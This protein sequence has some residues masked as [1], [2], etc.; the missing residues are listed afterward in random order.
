VTTDFR[1][2]TAA[3]LGATNV[4]KST[5]VNRLLDFKVAITSRKPQT[6]RHRIRGVLTT[7]AAQTILI[8]TPG[9]HQPQG[10]L[11]KK[12][13]QT[14]VAALDG[15]DLVALVAD[16]TDRTREDTRRAVAILQQTSGP[17]I[18]VINK[19]DL[20]TKLSLLPIMAEVASWDAFE[21]V[22][23]VSA[24][25]GDGIEV[26]RAE[27]ESRL[28]MGEPIFP[29]EVPTDRTERFLIGELIREQ[30]IRATHQEV[31]YG[32]A[33]EVDRFQEPDRPGKPVV[34]QA[35]IHVEQIGQKGIVIGQG[36]Q[37]IK[38]IGQ[39]ARREMERLLGTRVY[40]DLRVAVSPD[41]AR[42][43]GSLR[44]FGVE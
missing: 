43:E 25:T 30:V 32:A 38:R 23:P 42:R 6:T 39:A 24:R 40:L 22:V 37:M 26:L 33:V 16:V 8:D 13:V 41:W 34:I 28:P 29:P 19:I 3:L 7:D 9:I 15:V 11:G 17:K 20:V 5:L 31:P 2:G 12:L 21:A 18:A 1:C 14:A 10:L 4:G 27:I 36:G 44:R 35:T